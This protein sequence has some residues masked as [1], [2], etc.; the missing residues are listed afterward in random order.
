MNLPNGVEQIDY[1]AF[2]NCNRM[3]MIEL[4][5]SIIDIGCYAFANCSALTELRLPVSWSIISL[6][7]SPYEGKYYLDYGHIF[8]GCTL[9]RRIEFLK[10]Q[11]E[12]QIMR[13]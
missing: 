8:D 1:G 9:L 2:E 11:H 10:E 7:S 3:L 12:C 5:D 13:C 6:A 4:P